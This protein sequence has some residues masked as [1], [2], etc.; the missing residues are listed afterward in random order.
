VLL[1]THIEIAAPPERVWAVLADFPR[2]PDWNPFI[3][4]IAGTPALGSRLT[5][6]LQPPGAKA[7]TFHPRV[8]AAH[9]PRELRWRGRFLLPGLLD[10][11]HSFVIEPLPGGGVVLHHAERFSG[12]LRA[13]VPAGTR[14]GFDAMNRALKARAESA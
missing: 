5:V 14:T 8:L 6:T 7:M 12:L 3:R 11:E 1:E 13:L 4:A 10:G 2:Y 9:P